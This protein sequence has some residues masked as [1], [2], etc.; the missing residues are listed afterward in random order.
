M[1]KVGVLTGLSCCEFSSYSE[2]YS[3]STTQRTKICWH[4]S[5]DRFCYTYW[6][7]LIYNPYMYISISIYALFKFQSIKRVGF[8]VYFLEFQAMKLSRLFSFFVADIKIITPNKVQCFTTVSA[9]LRKITK[10]T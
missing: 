5:S 6:T 2:N 4:N 10:N 8:R 1:F 3:V 7:L 9:R